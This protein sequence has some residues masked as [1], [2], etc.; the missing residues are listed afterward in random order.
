MRR[1]SFLIRVGIALLVA[2]TILAYVFPSELFPINVDS[3]E[4][5][6]DMLQNLPSYFLAGIKILSNLVG[7]TSLITGI[8]IY[9]QDKRKGTVSYF[10]VQNNPV[11]VTQQTM[12]AFIPGLDLYASF[13]VKKLTTYFLVIFAIGIPAIIL[14]SLLSNFSYNYLL[15]EGIVLPVAIYLIRRWSKEW[16]EQFLN[17]STNEQ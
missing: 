11:D 12:F 5:D 4:K 13:K 14:V 1:S 6:S 10:S 9:V 3:G 2:N 17:N 16:N 8:A 15:V 7:F